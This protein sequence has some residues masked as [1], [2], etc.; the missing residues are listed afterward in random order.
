MVFFS[1]VRQFAVKSVFAL[2][3]ALTA[4][5]FAACQPDAGND[6]VD[7]HKLNQSLIGTWEDEGEWAGDS[8]AI[9]DTHLSYGYGDDFVSY[10]GA[11]KYT[12]N[13]TPT[14]GVIIIEYDADHKPEYY[15][16][17][18]PD[19]YEPIG[20][21]LPLKGNFIG[22]YYKDLKPGVSVQMGGAYTDGGAE[23]ATLDAAIAM[24]TV[25]YADTYMSYYGTYTRQP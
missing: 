5:S 24:F 19:T 11:I 21:P 14:A 4:F 17:Y 23:V 13:F 1:S 6:F 10:A 8:Y 2:V 22:I 9:T 25:G 18:D 12:S 16:G 7:D 15:A 3:A 20:D